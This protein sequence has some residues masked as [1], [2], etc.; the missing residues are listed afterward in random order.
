MPKAPHQ[1]YATCLQREWRNIIQRASIGFLVALKRYHRNCIEHLKHQATRLE[2]SMVLSSRRGKSI[3]RMDSVKATYNKWQCRLGERRR[4]KLENLVSC[5]P[6]YVIASQRAKRRRRRFKRR[7]AMTRPQTDPDSTSTVVNISGVT[8]SD[9]ETALLSKGLSFCPTPRHFDRNQL[10][11]DIESF[12]RRLRLKEFF[13]DLEEDQDEVSPFRPPSTWMPPKERDAALEIYIK[14]VRAEVDHQSRL[15][16]KKRARDNLLPRERQALRTLR[17]RKDIVIKP[18]DKGSAVVILSKEDYIKEAMRQLN[19]ASHYRKLPSDPTMKISTEIKEVVNGLFTRGLID[20]HSKEFLT[21]QHP[22]IARFYL[23]PKIHKPGC[24]GR[25]IVS[26]SGAPTE[27]I[28]SFVDFFLKPC[29][30]RISS[31]IRDTTDFLNKLRALPQLPTGSLLVTL[32]ASSLYTNI[33]HNEGITACEEALNS[34]ELLIPPTADLCRL[35]KLILSANS[36]TFNEEYYLQVH[37]TAMGTR[38]APSYANLFMGKLEQMFLHTQ[39]KVPLVWWRYID[40]IFAVWTHGEPALQLFVDELNCFHD[41]IKFTANWSTKEVVFLDTR[42]YLRNS[43]VETDLHI[44]PT[45]THQY[46]RTDSC[47]PRH[48]K[49]AIPYGQALRLR[50]ICSEQDNL[51]RRCDELKTHL[52]NRGYEKNLLRE[53]IQRAVSIPRET[54]LRVK[55]HQEK[56]SR[57]PLVVTYHPLLPSFASITRRH[58]HILHITER[59]RTAFP[60][61]PLIAFRRPKNLKDLLVRA[62]LTS[63]RRE[64]PG[65]FRCGSV[66]CKT[67]PILLT[68][69]VFTSHTTGEQFKVKGRA[70]CK[71]YNIIYLIQCRRCGHQ[72]VGETGQPLHNRVNGHRFDILHHRTNESPVAAHFNSTL[73]TVEDLTIMVIDQL[74]DQDPTLRK[75]RESRWI[76]ALGTSFP[77]G[78]NLRVDS[79]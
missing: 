67:C 13:I 45:D 22:K 31:Y 56:T 41:T 74:F 58:L 70:S 75:L 50:R 30:S 79:L 17:E 68:T 38:M 37:G 36:F 44:K 14:K 4:R 73:H 72:Y 21:P 76:R 42:V 19:N 2:K 40:D 3:V 34:R 63:A 5:F 39:E 6:I 62:Q 28:S 47:H 52:L 65:N 54:C 57:T 77:R 29:V 24:P 25:P 1:E 46:L 32:D 20:R 48:C 78:M 53:E 49:T 18:A 51:R 26:S 16:H 12:F 60:S 8:L 55:E 10:V 9:A 66:R 64:T 27:N 23:L 69:D 43:L 35:I 71:S 7:K 59:L 33:P 11:D 15:Q 61:P